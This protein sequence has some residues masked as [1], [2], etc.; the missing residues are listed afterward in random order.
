MKY[1]ESE[2]FENLKDAYL[3]KSVE[4]DK[5]KINID[6]NFDKTPSDDELITLNLF[7]NGLSKTIKVNQIETRK[8]FENPEENTVKEYISHHLAEI[9]KNEL[10]QLIDSNS[11]TKSDEEKLFEKFKLTRIGIYP[12]DH[13]QYAIFDYTIGE[14]FTQY[15]L[16]IITDK[17]GKIIEITI[18]S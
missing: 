5:Q 16:V 4:I 14:K 6:L 18:E 11:K 10:N 1:F 8:E 3:I 2:N 13:K 15:L 9:P 7:L 12:Q 17:D